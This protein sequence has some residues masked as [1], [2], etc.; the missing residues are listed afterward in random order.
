MTALVEPP[1]AA[2]ARM[3]FSNAPRVSDRAT[4]AGPPRPARR[5]PAGR[6]RDLVAAGVD[7]RPG[8]RPGQLHAERL[9]HARHRRRR[10]HRHAVPV[11]AGHA[12][13]GDG[14]LGGGHPAGLHLG[15][16]LPD[17]GAR[18]DVLTAELAV[19]HRPAGDHDR[20]AGRRSPRAISRPG[21]VLS[22]PDSSTTPSSGLARIS[23]SAVHGQ[24]VAV[25]HRRRAASASRRW[26]SRGTRAGSR[27]PARRRA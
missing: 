22:Q 4:A 23:S 15:L 1:I 3:A 24:Q 9:G 21:V 17:V 11:G 19:E 16:E 25:E 13:L 18:A 27:P 8:R 12:A 20:R 2:L 7:R 26:P 10:A 5:S 6:L 14:A